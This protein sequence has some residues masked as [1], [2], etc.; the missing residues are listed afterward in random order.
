VA[1]Q[2][3]GAREG[4]THKVENKDN[5]INNDKAKKAKGKK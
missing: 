4:E 5:D 3:E 1:A 2:G